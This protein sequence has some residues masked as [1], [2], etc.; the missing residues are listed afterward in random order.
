MMNMTPTPAQIT[1]QMAEAIAL[2]AKAVVAVVDNPKALGEALKGYEG[3]YELTG[4]Q[5]ARHAQAMQ[6]MADA[7][8]R[9]AKLRQREDALRAAEQTSARRAAELD[10]LYEQHSKNVEEANRQGASWRTLHDQLVERGRAADERDEAQAAT[11]KRQG[12][13]AERL[14]KLADDFKKKQDATEEYK[15]KL[16]A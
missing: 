14:R 12:R 10:K 15:A 3:Q 13:E 2:V 7:D 11:D 8:G 6:F 5:Q 9:E 16:S 4:E 1:P